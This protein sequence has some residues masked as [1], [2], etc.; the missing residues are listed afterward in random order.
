[1]ADQIERRFFRGELRAQGEGDERHII[2]YAAVFNSLSEDLGGW[3]EM[4]EP[5]AFANTIQ[6]DDVRG[7]YNH[8][9]T[10]VL[11]R[12][13]AGTLI[14]VED[15]IGL[16]YEIIPPD[17]SYSRDLMVS[18]DRGDVNQSS[19]GFNV[20]KGGDDW[21]D[22]TDSQ[23]FPIRILREVK[24]FDVSPVTFPAYPVTSVAVRDMAQHLAGRA[25]SQETD[26][27]RAAGRLALRKRRLELVSKL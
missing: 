1:M 14:L 24:L 17:T 19:F 8:E 15:E 2:G 22:P 25:T 26:L 10:M 21:I 12:N 27:E 20:P 13:K 3:K 7:L 23:P 9:P 11:G 4:I 6:V 16:R 5:G 18:I